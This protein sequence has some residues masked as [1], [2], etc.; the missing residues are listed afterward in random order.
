MVTWV[1]A[2]DWDTFQFHRLWRRS[3]RRSSR[4]R[5]GRLKKVCNG[6]RM[7][8]ATVWHSELTAARRGSRETPDMRPHPTGAALTGSRGPGMG[9]EGRCQGEELHHRGALA[10]RLC[11]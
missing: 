9:G 5:G 6:F 3:P 4:R 8:C 2:P 11:P 7:K 1:E 10:R